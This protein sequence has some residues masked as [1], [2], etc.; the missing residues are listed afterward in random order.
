MHCQNKIKNIIFPFQSAIYK[1]IAI[2]LT[3]L[4]NDDALN[5]KVYDKTGFL[6]LCIIFLMSALKHSFFC[7][8]S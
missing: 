6:G 2:K 3:G 5:L 7:T 4:C 1:L 8:T